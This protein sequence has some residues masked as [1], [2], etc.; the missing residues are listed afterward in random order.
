MVGSSVREEVLV[1]VHT[2]PVCHMQVEEDSAAGVS[3]HQGKR[4]YFC[5][6][7]CKER[8]DRNPGQYLGAAR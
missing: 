4:Y 6:R 2:D 7:G 5:S 8:F 1:P 3:E